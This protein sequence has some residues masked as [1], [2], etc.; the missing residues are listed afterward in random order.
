MAE[1]NGFYY[2]R[3]R[4]YDPLN[5]RFISEDPLGFD[6]GDVNLYVYSGNNPVLLVDPWGLTWQQDVEFVA[7]GVGAIIVESHIYLAEQFS[8]QL[9]TAL[10]LGRIGRMAQLSHIESAVLDNSIKTGAILNAVGGTEGRD[11]AERIDSRISS[12]RT[13][14]YGSGNTI[15]QNNIS[16]GIQSSNTN[17]YSGSYK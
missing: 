16:G 5:G 13:D 2:M 17:S 14:V 3:A 11:L 7:R 8:Q 4:Y 1:T 10:A 9:V 15:S 12:I 6:G